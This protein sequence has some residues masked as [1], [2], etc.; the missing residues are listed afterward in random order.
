MY[1]DSFEPSP[2]RRRLNTT[3][4]LFRALGVDVRISWT[5]AIVPLVVFLTIWDAPGMKFPAKAA[6]AIGWTVGLYACVYAHEMG[7][8]LMGR[9]L[10]VTSSRMTLRALG[11]LAH[12]DS[13]APDPKGEILIA[14]AGPATHLVWLALL[15]P[16]YWAVGEFA[17]PS[18]YLVEFALDWFIHLQFVLLGFNLLPL[19]PMDGGRVLRGILARTGKRHANHASMLTAQVGMAG[20]LILGRAG[21]V[22]M[23]GQDHEVFGLGDFSF[24]LVWIGIANW[25]SCRRLMVEARWSDGPYAPTES[26]KRSLGGSDPFAESLAESARLT[27]KADKERKKAEEKQKQAQDERAALQARVDALLD[28]IN[29]VGGIGN[30]SASERKELA[31]ASEK[32]AK[33][34]GG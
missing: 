19:Y 31:S 1:R 11:G 7:H 15:Y 16:A 23:F 6:I 27:E 26:W 22:G 8:I 14:L 3:W 32:L 4:P 2:W 30:L 10:G 29:E 17:P 25:S 5:I 13:P 33:F 28:R 20:A 9:R 18:W 12:M 34:D 21:L 24:L